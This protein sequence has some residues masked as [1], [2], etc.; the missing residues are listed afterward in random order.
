[1]ELA[2]WLLR[3]PS[4]AMLAGVLS[5]H[6]AL[7]QSI[8]P[9]QGHLSD[10]AGRG[11]CIEALEIWVLREEISMRAMEK[12]FA[13]QSDFLTYCFQKAQSWRGITCVFPASEC[14]WFWWCEMGTWGEGVN[15]YKGR[16]KD[17]WEALLFESLER[18]LILPNTL[19]FFPAEK[20][21]Q[22]EKSKCFGIGHIC[23]WILAVAV[24]ML[25]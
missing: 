19:S 5:G 11:W 8:Q 4:F 22:G 3:A 18:L 2:S 13:F 17:K 24:M 1:M 10:G 25:A 12:E 16:K 23:A 9:L 6:C 20:V 7:F 15:K 14:A 21:S